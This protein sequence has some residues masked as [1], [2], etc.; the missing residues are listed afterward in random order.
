MIRILHVVTF[1]GRGGL[2]TMLMNYYRHIDRT[3]IQFDFLVHRNF[4]ADYDDEIEKL[5]GKIHRL[6]RLVPWNKSYLDALNEFFKNHSEYR[7][8]HVHQ[9]C[10]SSVILKAAYKNNVPVRI[11]HSHNSNQTKN[12]KYP[13]KLFYKKFISKY[14]TDLMACST[15]AGAWMFNQ[16]RFKVL[17]NAIDVKLYKHST[18]KRVLARERLGIPQDAFVVGHVGRFET[19]K[20][21]SFLIDVFNEVK[22]QNNNSV[23]LLI[24]DGELKSEIEAK[25]ISLGIQDS[26]IFTGVRCDVCD[27][28]NTMDVF[29]MPSLYEGVSLSVVEAVANNLPCF[30]TDNIS[31]DLEHIECITR[32]SL[33]Q[34]PDVW[35][36][37]ILK[38]C[39]NT[40][41]E[42]VNKQLI[43][44]GYDIHKNI[45]ELTE[46][47]I[48]KWN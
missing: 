10:L 1:M 31:T 41:S 22:N 44:N 30:V 16:S 38:T 14:A 11:A 40:R 33:R 47:Y 25:T 6:P 23:L 32:V 7:I 42:N 43:V 20:N 48:K 2:E 4:R 5:G 21:H 9:D 18:E 27:L 36:N 45:N 13:I 34:K 24:G 15:E 39:N 35:A 19:Q 29:V 28:L 37:I 12:L 8:V 46:F 26:V 3:K 17:R